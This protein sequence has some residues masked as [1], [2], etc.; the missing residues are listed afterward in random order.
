MIVEKEDS[1]IT[2]SG[3]T[4]EYIYHSRLVSCLNG[5]GCSIGKEVDVQDVF[6]SKERKEIQSKWRKAKVQSILLSMLS[7]IGSHRTFDVFK[8]PT[9]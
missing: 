3:L 5:T 2:T 7:F 4:T 9:K 6:L 8:S 1:M